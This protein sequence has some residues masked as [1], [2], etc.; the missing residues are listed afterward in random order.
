MKIKKENSF[1][2]LLIV[3]FLMISLVGIYLGKKQTTKTIDTHTKKLE[4]QQQ[5]DEISS[6]EED[7]KA[8]DLSE[9]DKELK[10]IEAE[11]SGI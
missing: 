7:L 5:S 9:L 8:T 11:L 4:I 3:A 6:I 2:I 1:L 10:N